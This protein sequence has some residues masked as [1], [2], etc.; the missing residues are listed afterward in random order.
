M[1]E[2]EIIDNERNRYKIIFPDCKKIY[3]YNSLRKIIRRRTKITAFSPN[4]TI[5]LDSFS[6]FYPKLKLFRFFLFSL[7]T[8]FRLARKRINNDDIRVILNRN[9]T[10]QREKIFGMKYKRG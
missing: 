5:V 8:V 10:P 1:F 6:T 2:G 7:K 4:L 3:I 9:R